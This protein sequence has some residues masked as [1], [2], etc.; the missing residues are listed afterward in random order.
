MV[1]QTPDIVFQ[2]LQLVALALPAVAIYLQVL[3]SVFARARREGPTRGDP[4]QARGVVVIPELEREYDFLFGLGALVSLIGSAFFLVLRVLI[5]CSLL[6]TVSVGLIAIA[7]FLFAI[8][9]VLTI[10]HSISKI[11]K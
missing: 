4:I 10:R 7:L 9:T 2:L 8:S 5:P 6:V 11:S 1:V 3:S